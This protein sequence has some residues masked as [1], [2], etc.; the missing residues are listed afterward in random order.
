MIPMIIASSNTVVTCLVIYNIPKFFFQIPNGYFA[1]TYASSDLSGVSTRYDTSQRCL[2]S[3]Q[4]SLY[5]GRIV[6]GEYEYPVD[7][8]E[9]EEE[10]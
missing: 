4:R 3:L 1:E 9:E 8:T 10:D 7:P 5:V 6:N 2:P